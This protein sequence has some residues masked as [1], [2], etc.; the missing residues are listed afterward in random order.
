[1]ISFPKVYLSTKKALNALLTQA[2]LFLHFYLPVCKTAVASSI[3]YW[4]TVYWF[5]S[6]IKDIW[7]EEN[8][9]FGNFCQDSLRKTNTKKASE[10]IQ[11]PGYV[12]ELDIIFSLVHKVIMLLCKI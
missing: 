7:W 1:M 12:A 4:C 2:Q 9:E 11:A 3:I 8:S 10:S 5:L 6:K